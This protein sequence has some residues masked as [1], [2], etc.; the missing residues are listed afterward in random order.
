[1]A[2]HDNVGNLSLFRFSPKIPSSNDFH[3]L[4]ALVHSAMREIRADAVVGRDIDPK[5]ALN[6]I[7]TRSHVVD[8]WKTLN[9]LRETFGFLLPGAYEIG[10]KV[11]Y[12]VSHFIT[13]VPRCSLRDNVFALLTK[14]SHPSMADG[15]NVVAPS[16]GKLSAKKYEARLN[17]GIAAGN[18]GKHK[19]AAKFFRACV[20]DDPED[21]SPHYLLAQALAALGGP[22]QALE[23]L[24][25][26]QALGGADLDEIRRALITSHFNVANAAFNKKDYRLART[27][28]SQ[29]VHLDPT[30]VEAHRH[31]M[32]ALGAHGEF[33]AALWHAAILLDGHR[34]DPCV[35]LDVARLFLK[36][37]ECDRAIHHAEVALALR[38]E[39]LEASALREHAQRIEQR[40]SHGPGE[41]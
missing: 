14:I 31:L 20:A 29:V 38:P 37:G 2:S 3:E 10:P 30:D 19:K 18:A 21:G 28:Y 40:K 1:M 12:M 35:Q 32:E 9:R 15:E 26:A 7:G 33:D 16:L 6:W 22:A 11:D 41:V 17:A 39:W 25:K 5:M 36:A 4:N 13:A 23:H 24:Y 34:E 8:D 27:H